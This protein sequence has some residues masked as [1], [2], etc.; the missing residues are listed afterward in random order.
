MM[1]K[2]LDEIFELTPQGKEGVFLSLAI[3][4]SISTRQWRIKKTRQIFDLAEGTAAS[5]K[6]NS[7]YFLSFFALFDFFRGR[8]EVVKKGEYDWCKNND[9]RLWCVI[10]IP[11]FN[12][13]NR[14]S[15]SI[16][17]LVL[18]FGLFIAK[19]EVLKEP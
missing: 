14:K 5:A 15:R 10:A 8:K 7:F 13:D 18:Y 6:S 2:S 1:W 3:N 17:D 11:N 9:G 4:Q 19:R 12:Y 16:R